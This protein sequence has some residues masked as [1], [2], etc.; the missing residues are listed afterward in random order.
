MSEYFPEREPKIFR[1]AVL[2]QNFDKFDGLKFDEG[3]SVRR[4]NL[5]K[6]KREDN[7]L[8]FNTNDLNHL[9]DAAKDLMSH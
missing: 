5:L 1:I 6:I 3:L 7:R 2:F 9:K 8:V 4:W